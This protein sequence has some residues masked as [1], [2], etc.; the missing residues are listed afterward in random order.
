VS[1]A[2]IIKM[3]GEKNRRLSPAWDVD[4]QTTQQLKVRC[5]IPIT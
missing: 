5:G 2:G 4:G 3:A 1:E